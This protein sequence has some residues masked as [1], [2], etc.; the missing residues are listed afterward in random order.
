V[1]TCP[2]SHSNPANTPANTS[3][4]DTPRVR[5]SRNSS[6]ASA[7]KSA[8]PPAISTRAKGAIQPWSLASTMKGSVIQ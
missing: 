7:Q 4:T 8:R 6:A 3:T 2:R 1:K 5:I